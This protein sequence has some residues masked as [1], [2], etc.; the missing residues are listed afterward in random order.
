MYEVGAVAVSLRVE[1]YLLGMCGGW[2]GG[3]GWRGDGESTATDRL[4]TCGHHPYLLL[5]LLLSLLLLDEGLVLLSDLLLPYVG[6][7]R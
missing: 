3:G 6:L 4:S 2:G 5:L 1:Q 7:L